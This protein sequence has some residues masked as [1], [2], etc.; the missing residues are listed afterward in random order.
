[1]RVALRNAATLALMETDLVLL[2]DSLAALPQVLT[3]GQRIVNGALD[4]F[5]LFF[6]Q[7]GTQLLLILGLLLLDWQHFPYT[8]R[9]GS[10]VSVYTI[11]IPNILLSVWAA[12]GK[13]TPEL[14][15]RRLLHFVLPA[16]ITTSILVAGVYSWF[17]AR[18]GDVPYAQTAAMFALLFAGFVRVLFVQ[19][20]TWFWVG[21]N[22]FSGDRRVFGLVLAAAG[23]YAVSFALPIMRQWFTI[24]W[25]QRPLEYVVVAAAAAIWMF[26]LRA[27][28]RSRRLRSYARIDLAPTPHKEPALPGARQGPYPAPASPAQSSP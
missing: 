17:L 14:M 24:D 23:L 4:A 2:A 12:A 26:V 25:L 5:R 18:T 10:V 9:Q 7:A 20:P 22:V 21:G 13:M 6:S 11:A 15:K 16:V 28:W 1:L 19:P 3:A 27:L 8:F